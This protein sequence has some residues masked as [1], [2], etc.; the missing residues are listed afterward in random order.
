MVA[1]FSAPQSCINL[2]VVQMLLTSLPERG[3]S[4]LVSLYTVVITLS[5]SLLPLLGVHLYT[6]LG[7]NAR[8][9]FALNRG[10]VSSARLLASHLHRALSPRAGVGFSAPARPLLFRFSVPRALMARVWHSPKSM[11]SCKIKAHFAPSVMGECFSSEK[12]YGFS[13]RK[14]P[15]DRQSPVDTITHEGEA[16]PSSIPSGIMLLYR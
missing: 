15:A 2:C 12:S 6:F 7:A 4:F 5:N 13:Y 11:A 1:I 8:A 14:R 3:R 9:L 16:S 10:R